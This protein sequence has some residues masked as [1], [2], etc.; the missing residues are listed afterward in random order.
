MTDDPN[1]PTLRMPP[2]FRPTRGPTPTRSRRLG[3]AARPQ[4]PA[5]APTASA[6]P[7][8]PRPLP[9]RPGSTPTPTSDAGSRRRPSCSASSCSAIGLWFFA[10][11]TL[12]LDT[13]ATSAGVRRGRSSSSSSA[14]GS[15]WARSAVA[16]IVSDEPEPRR[17]RAPGAGR[18]AA[19]DRGPVRRG[20]R[21]GGAR[22][23]IALAHWRSVREALF[24]DAPPVAGPPGRA[25]RRSAAAHFDHDPALRFDVP[26]SVGAGQPPPGWPGRARRSA[27]PEQRRPIAGLQPDRHG[28]GP[29]PATAPPLSVFWMAGYAGGLFLPF[30]DATNGPIDLR[31]RALP[32]GRGQERRPGRPVAT[33]PLILDFNFAFQ[34]S[35]AFDPRWACPLAPAGEPAGPRGAG[36]RARRAAG[37]GATAPWTVRSKP[38]RDLRG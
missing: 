16:S 24:R 35:C 7:C 26:S 2:R 14:R 28:P 12:G 25:R 15:S 32:P 11:Q 38:A 1:D 27:L 30:R 8:P 9:N 10:S 18:L 31:R 20:P 37:S 36:R 33:R 4:P 19:P 34:P 22:S 6:R 13:A 29:V 3:R 5:D 17:R 23:G 21:H